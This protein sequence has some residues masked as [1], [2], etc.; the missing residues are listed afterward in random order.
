M[1]YRYF[2]VIIKSLVLFGMW[3]N[4]LQKYSLCMSTQNLS[5]LN[6]SIRA[7]T[8]FVIVDVQAV[9]FCTRNLY[10]VDMYNTSI[11]LTITTKPTAQKEFRTAAMLFY[12]TQ[13]EIIAKF[14]YFV[15]VIIS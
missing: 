11:S 14:T 4:L 8:M 12:F 6:C 13:K 15:N 1:C 3:G 10:V 2:S 7:A 9:F 5:S